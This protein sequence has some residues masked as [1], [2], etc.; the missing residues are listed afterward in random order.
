MAN[1]TE[2]VVIGGGV[3]GT[4]IAYHLARRGARVTVVERDHLAS[5]ASGA[6][7]GG[8]RQINRD[9]REMPLAIASIARWATL[10]EELGS[11]CEFRMGGQ[12]RA[13]ER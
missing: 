10:E 7:A 2:I 6:S 9:P 11:D 12:L 13:C 1:R 8:V 4:S 3:I 5:Q